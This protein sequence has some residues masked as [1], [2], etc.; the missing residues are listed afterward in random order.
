MDWMLT[1]DR[2]RNL[3][4]KPED[5]LREMLLELGITPDKEVIAHCQT[6]LRSAHTYIVLKSLGQSRIRGY[7][8]S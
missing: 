2:A 3:R 1:I 5:E 4:L 7:D 6:H 8:G